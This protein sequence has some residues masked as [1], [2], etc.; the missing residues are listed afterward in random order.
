MLTWHQTPLEIDQYSHLV[1]PNM[2]KNPQICD[3]FF[4]WSLKIRENNERKNILVAQI[5]VIFRCLIKGFRPKVFYY[6]SEN[7]AKK[8]NCKC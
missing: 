8:K 6:L 5:C 1:Y 7:L 3:F 2:H 4:H